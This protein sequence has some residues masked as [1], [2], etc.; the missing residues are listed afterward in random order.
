MNYLTEYSNSMPNLCFYYAAKFVGD[1]VAKDIVQ[2]TFAN[3]WT[4]QSLVIT[5][6]LNSLLFTTIRNLCLQQ[7]EK[8]KVRNK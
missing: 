2:D 4:D 7:L 3:L 1:E 5:K 8:Q 6:S